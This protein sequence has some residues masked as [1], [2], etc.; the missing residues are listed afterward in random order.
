MSH[1]PD[2]ALATALLAHPSWPTNTRITLQDEWEVF[3][4]PSVSVTTLR[5]DSAADQDRSVVDTTMDLSV[6]ETDPFRVRALVGVV[7]DVLT[8]LD[9]VSTP[10]GDIVNVQVG[11]PHAVPVGT[12]NQAPDG[13]NVYRQALGI[14]VVSA[15]QGEGV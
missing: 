14:R 13:S 7:A 12:D 2:A 10:H 15:P 1:A 5:P 11:Q 4:T 8:T 6:W 9:G 3:P